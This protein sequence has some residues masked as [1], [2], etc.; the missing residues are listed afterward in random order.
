MLLFQYIFQIEVNLKLVCIESICQLVLYK[1]LDV[2]FFKIH[3]PVE[4][5]KKRISGEFSEGIMI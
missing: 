1:Y 4:K 3:K 2:H 5:P